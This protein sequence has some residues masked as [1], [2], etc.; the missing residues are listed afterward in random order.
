MRTLGNILWHIPFLGFLTAFGTLIVGGLMMATIIG[1]PFGLTLIRLSKYFLAPF[2]YV[3]VP[4]SDVNPIEYPAW[5]IFGIFVW[6]LYLPFGIVLSLVLMV[7]IVGMFCSVVGI[8]AALALAKVLPT[9][10]TPIN[11]KCVSVAVNDGFQLRQVHMQ[12]GQVQ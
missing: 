4:S 9:Y 6:I 11:T 3:M 8:P 1:A 10:L 5:R 12:T 7:Q 2:S